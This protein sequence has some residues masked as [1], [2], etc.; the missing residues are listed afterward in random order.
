M[1]SLTT[2]ANVIT[3]ENVIDEETTIV[4]DFKYLGLDLSN[5]YSN[6]NNDYYYVVAMS[7]QYLNLEEIQTYFYIYYPIETI[8]KKNIKIQYFIDNNDLQSVD[9]EYISYDVLHCIIKVKGFKYANRLKNEIV[10][11]SCSIGSYVYPST[12]KATVRH[13]VNDDSS[14]SLEMNFDTVLFIDEIQAVNVLVPNDNKIF[15]SVRQWWD[16]FWC[17]GRRDLFVSFYNFNFPSGV[18]ADKLNSATFTYLYERFERVSRRSNIFTQDWHVV[19]STLLESETLVKEYLPSTYKFSS[20]GSS[21]TLEF[22]TFYLGNR[23]VDNQFGYL[24]FEETQKSMFNY[25]CSVLLDSYINT[26]IYWEDWDTTHRSYDTEISNIR[27]LALQWEKDGVKYSAQVYNEPVDSEDVVPMVKKEWWQ[28]VIDL[29]IEKMPY[30]I[31]IVLV[32]VV[33]TPL[34]IQLVFSVISGLMSMVFSIFRR[35]R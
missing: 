20:N 7:E 32:G 15:S 3:Y 23:V 10:V 11:K 30:S 21:T 18:T 13:S 35:K 8:E 17:G 4:N 27:L 2:F 28:K 26:D 6:E 16:N 25:D 29:F 1:F 9:C 33:A 5:Y 34:L 31:I 19:E 14:M 12:F 24:E 22:P